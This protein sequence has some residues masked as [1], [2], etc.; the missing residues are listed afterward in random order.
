MANAAERIAT[1]QEGREEEQEAV[2]VWLK[3]KRD[4]IGLGGLA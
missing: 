1:R 3:G 4:E 2:V